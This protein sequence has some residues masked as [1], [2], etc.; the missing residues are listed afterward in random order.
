MKHKATVTFEFDSKNYPESPEVVIQKM[1]ENK[2]VFPAPIKP[3]QIKVEK[4]A[5]K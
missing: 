3:S 1:M 5:E 2:Y 4:V